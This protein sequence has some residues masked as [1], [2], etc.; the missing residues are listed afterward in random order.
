MTQ[1]FS[2]SDLVLN[3]F[4]ARLANELVPFEKLMSWN[5]LSG[6]FDDRNK[7]RVQEQF[8]PNY[9]VTTTTDGVADLSGGVQDSV[10]GSEVYQINKTFGASFG[11]Q[12]FAK[13]RDFASAREN[14]ALKSLTQRMGER[15]G[16]YLITTASLASYN[17]VGSAGVALTDVN[18]VTSA[19]TR[20]KEEGVPDGSMG[21]IMNF[22]DRQGLGDQVLNLPGPAADAAR[23]L[24]KGFDGAV[25]GVPTYFTQQLGTVTIGNDVTGL[26]V[27]GATQNVNYKDVAISAQPGQYLTQTLA[28]AGL[29]ATT[30]TITAGTVFTVAGM[31]A[32]D[33]RAGVSLGR[34]QQFTV[35]TGATADGSGHATIR[36]A[37]AII[38]QGSGS[39]GDVNVNTAHATVDAAPADTA[40]I[41]A[42]GTASTTY[43]PRLMLSK[44]SIEISTMDLVLPYTGKGS[45][46]KLPNLPLSVRMWQHSVF[47]TPSASPH[48]VTRFDVAL[49]A[50]IRDR[51]KICRFNGT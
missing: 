26:N 37:P 20:L 35:V 39:G 21:A 45:R 28:I 50:N 4:V 2:Q 38:V 25:A 46:Q 27:N 6:E 11:M 42:V 34:L 47:E 32:W 15:I 36:I 33:N 29:T 49:T 14:Q 12:D 41:T 40:A 22:S 8:A 1:A 24:R 5:K 3:V 43:R 9:E 18:D 23:S 17:W 16:Q 44:D 30:G 51:R 7:L 48:H 13:I 31:N 10:F 19:Y